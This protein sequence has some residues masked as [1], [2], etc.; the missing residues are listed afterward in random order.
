MKKYAVFLLIIC[1]LFN[2]TGTADEQY[3]LKVENIPVSV[4]EAYIYILNAEKEYADIADYYASY[5][6]IDFWSMEYTNGMTVSQMIK[7]DVFK[8][9]L[10]MNV[11]YSM[12]GEKK[13]TLSSSEKTACRED[14]E[15]TYALLPVTSAALID[16]N[17]LAR[18]FEKQRLA[19]RMYS[20][21][22][23]ETEIDEESVISSID[24]N[25]YKTYEVEYLFRSLTDYTAQ[26]GAQMISKEKEREIHDAFNSAKTS[27]SLKDAAEKL[28]SLDI[29]YASASFSSNDE[30]IEEKLIKTVMRLSPGEISGTVKTDYGL[31]LIRLIDDS[32]TEAYDTAVADALRAAREE[33]FSAEYNQL[34]LNADYEINVSFWDAVMPGKTELP[35]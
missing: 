33:A 35:D 27:P 2:I 29:L 20:M 1:L 32:G 17:S 13:L 26:S 28:S 23:S 12:A 5:L 14:A 11:F 25:A 15:K 9:I 10:M 22:L 3:A 30:A 34:F 7:S 31:F 16:R 19:D 24:R 21:L 4:T 6:D 18:V 8:E